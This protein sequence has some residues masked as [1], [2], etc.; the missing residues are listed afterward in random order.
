[1]HQPESL[2][3]G[4]Q[5]LG[6][7]SL[8]VKTSYIDS[9]LGLTCHY[10]FV[11]QHFDRERLKMFWSPKCIRFCCKKEFILLLVNYIYLF[12]N[13]IIV[14]SGSSVSVL[15]PRSL[16]WPVLARPAWPMRKLATT[17][18]AAAAGTAA[19]SRCL[20]AHGSESHWDGS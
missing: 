18:S 1:M 7:N 13:D 3:T 16:T 11:G 5:P 10:H 17:A 8:H 4:G 6:A 14:S 15:G 20:P 12:L 19:A 2:P 9:K